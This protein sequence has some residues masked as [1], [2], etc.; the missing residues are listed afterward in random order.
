MNK[1]NIQKDIYKCREYYNN[2]IILDSST[3]NHFILAYNIL[4]P[5][6]SLRSVI[7]LISNTYFI[8]R[9]CKIIEIVY[10]A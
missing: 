10:V 8:N 1:Q 3:K 5:Q 9:S 7:K 2:F 4:Q 6:N